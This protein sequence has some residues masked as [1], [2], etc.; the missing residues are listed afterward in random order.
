MDYEKII[1][2]FDKGGLKHKLVE[3]FPKTG[4]WFVKNL[5]DKV[6]ELHLGKRDKDPFFYIKPGETSK[7]AT[8]FPL[9][10]N[11]KCEST[12]RNVLTWPQQ[13][14]AKAAATPVAG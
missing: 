11:G 12:V 1:V 7:L 8:S 9:V 10:L 13:Q 6:V 5:T 3:V 2:D 14:A 4:E